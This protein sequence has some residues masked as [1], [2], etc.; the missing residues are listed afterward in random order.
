MVGTDLEAPLEETKEEEIS[1]WFISL[2]DDF[3]G[4]AHNT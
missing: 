3:I 4:M 1:R 2:E